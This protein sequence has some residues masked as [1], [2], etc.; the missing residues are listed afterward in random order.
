MFVFC[1]PIQSR[2][3]CLVVFNIFSPF[4]EAVGFDKLTLYTGMRPLFEHKQQRK[5]LVW[6][7]SRISTYLFYVSFVMKT[8]TLHNPEG[9]RLGRSPPR[10]VL[11]FSLCQ[12]LNRHKQQS[13]SLVSEDLTLLNCHINMKNKA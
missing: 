6:E 9:A 11:I 2:S 8:G 3:F 7:A 1:G 5:S 10:I 12:K 13:K 4:T